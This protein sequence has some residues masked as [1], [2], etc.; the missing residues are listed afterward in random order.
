MSH[1]DFLLKFVLDVRFYFP[2][3]AG[4]QILYICATGL[5]AKKKSRSQKP[6]KKGKKEEK[7]REKNKLAKARKTRTSP[8]TL[9]LK[10][11]GLGKLWV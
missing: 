6:K 7:R 3:C 11:F 10:K 8:G 9:G 2:I 5:R 1:K 4:L